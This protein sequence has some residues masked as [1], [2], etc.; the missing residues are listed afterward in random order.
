[1]LV[2]NLINRLSVIIGRCDLIMEKLQ[3]EG[4]SPERLL[5]IR[6]FA[7]SMADELIQDGM[8]HDGIA[9]HRQ[10]IGQGR[11][12]RHLENEVTSR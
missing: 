6:S 4:G 10:Q 11:A 8:T 9:R 3:A 5:R 1:M 12:V 2:H 7:K